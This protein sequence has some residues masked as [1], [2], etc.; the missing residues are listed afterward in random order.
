MSSITL[1][2]SA[3]LSVIIVVYLLKVRKIGRKKERKKEGIYLSKTNKCVYSKK[4]SCKSDNNYEN[5]RTSH[6]PHI[7]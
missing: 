7:L 3:I 4:S 2:L 1:L 6:M 5:K